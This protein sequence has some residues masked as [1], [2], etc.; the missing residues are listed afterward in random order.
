MTQE[1][2]TAVPTDVVCLNAVELWYDFDDDCDVDLADF[3]TFA[4]TWLNCN[5]VAGN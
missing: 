5:R 4:A 1:Y 3:A 2:L